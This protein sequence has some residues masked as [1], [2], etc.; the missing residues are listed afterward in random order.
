MTWTENGSLPRK[1]ILQ[2]KL[3]G[4]R[5]KASHLIIGSPGNWSR[6]G[7]LDGNHP[8][9]VVQL[10]LALSLQL[11]LQLSNELSRRVLLVGALFFSLS[12]LPAGIRNPPE[13]PNRK[14]FSCKKKNGKWELLFLSQ[15]RVEL[16]VLCLALFDLATKR[17]PQGEEN[18]TFSCLRSDSRDV[19]PKDVN[20]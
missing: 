4:R 20:V 7:F 15:P 12:A 2:I 8:S 14:I 19:R 9:L 3:G 17:R 13:V 16:G 10:F 11:F 1:L 18:V 6:S 5:D